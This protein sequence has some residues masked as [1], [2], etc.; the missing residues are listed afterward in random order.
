MSMVQGQ[1]IDENVWKYFMPK[2]ARVMYKAYT[3]IREKRDETK[4]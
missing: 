4:E 1:I 3:K 2:F